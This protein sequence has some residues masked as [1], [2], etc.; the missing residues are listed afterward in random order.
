MDL[1]MGNSVELAAARAELAATRA[2]LALFR[3]QATLASTRVGELTARIDRLMQ[4]LAKQ[5][6]RIT[7]LLA[8]ALRKKN[9]K[10]AP[11]EAKP[12][13]SPPLD[14]AAL[15]AFA[16]RP[17]APAPRGAL[18]DRP[19]EKQTPT[20]RKALPS[21][22]PIDEST[23][24]PE[25]CPCGCETFDWIDEVV[26]EKLTAVASHQ[27]VRRTRRKTGR[28]RACGQRSTGEAP[29]SP[30]ERS[31]FT[32]S[33]LAWFIVQKF[34]L[35]TPLDRIRRL[36]NLQGIVLAKATLVSQTAA[37]TVLLDPIDG[38]HWKTL[39]AG[40]HLGSDA[41][42]FK[43]QI[44]GFGLHHGH[45]EVYHWDDTVVFQY[46]AE[47]GGV[48]QAEKL[49]KFKGTLL[50]DAESRYNRTAENPDILEANCLAH[51]R[52]KLRDAE[53]V[54]PILAAEGGAFLSAMF[55]LEVVAKEN[56]LAGATLLDWRQTH[57][58]PIS[59][60][61]RAWMQVVGPTLLDDDP[62]GKVIRYFEKHWDHLMRFLSDPE[63]PLDNSAS[64][65]AFQAVAKLRLNC[66][67]AGGTEGAHRAAVLLG[68]AA[69]CQRVE[70]DF[71]AYLNWVFI[72][73]GTHRH[74][75]TM[76]AAD[77]TPAAYK[78]AIAT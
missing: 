70:V 30:F 2:E 45:M 27:R 55:E 56:G 75:Y 51:P 57:T 25:R 66:L 67:F 46:V 64:E 3:E 14:A 20:G 22:L 68:V 61:F 26:E 48:T 18:N 37:A 63:L 24:F 11:G 32:C 5:A 42:G 52:R 4:E 36:L 29:P 12:P 13:E 58:R 43:V 23:V 35:L 21:H 7:E 16:G 15:A 8:I 54:Q 65:R 31:K 17:V 76:T 6:D 78:L 44:P 74:K 50:V 53:T 49:A 1:L 69:T 38:E 9:Q 40:N 10:K 34:Q 39:L 41:T 77:L 47:K 72:R 19:R 62:V 28:C 60:E 71:E 73:R 59:E 33:W